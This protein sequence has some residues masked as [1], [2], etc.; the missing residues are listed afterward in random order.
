M[1]VGHEVREEGGDVV[2]VCYCRRFP[3]WPGQA[4][5]QQC[6]V[7][8]PPVHLRSVEILWHVCSPGQAGAAQDRDHFVPGLA[9]RCSLGE[10]V[11]QDRR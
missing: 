10:M 2:A 11:D 4:S 8:M 7:S 9:N 6:N 1:I 5:L 3:R